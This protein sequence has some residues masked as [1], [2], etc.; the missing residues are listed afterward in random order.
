MK[1]YLEPDE[2]ERLERAAEFLRDKL[3][4][5]LL[6]RLGCRVSEVL[7]I[8]VNNIDFKH[9][10]ITIEHLK[11]R[12][13]LSCPKCGASLGKLHNFC[14]VCGLKVEKA[15]AQEKEHHRYRSLPVDKD[16][17][18][19]L[20]EYIKRGGAVSR[21]GKRIV[22]SLTRHRA[23]QIIRECADKAGLPQL[24]N[25]ESGKEHGVSP[26]K[27]RD[28]FAVHAVKLDDSGDGLRLLQEHLGH[29][30]IVTTMKYRKVSGEEQKEW[31][32][33][34]WQGGNKNG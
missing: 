33:K 3:L 29:Q 14:P 32:D 12:I 11:A 30:S 6:W 1:A 10:T 26:H 15:V 22:F 28:A 20:K 4:I 16:T 25:A 5:R 27:L 31:Y 24:V 34:L 18:D 7:G 23:W 2:V 21:N 19:L 9:G 13:K 17:L 8:T